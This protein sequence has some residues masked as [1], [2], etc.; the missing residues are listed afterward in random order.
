MQNTEIDWLIHAF[1]RLLFFEPL[2]PLENADLLLALKLLFFDLLELLL[3][4][5]YSSY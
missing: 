3:T 5:P 1:S 2:D 4:L